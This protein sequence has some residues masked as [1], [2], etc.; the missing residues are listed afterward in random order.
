MFSF[1]PSFKKHDIHVRISD[2]GR[3]VLN[4]SKLAAQ[5]ANTIIQNKEQLQR[6]DIVRIGRN[7]SSDEEVRSAPK[8]NEI[9]NIVSVEFVTTIADAQTKS[10]K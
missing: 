7:T 10:L 2:T 3:R 8:E 5:V 9:S 1:L 4:N 6:G